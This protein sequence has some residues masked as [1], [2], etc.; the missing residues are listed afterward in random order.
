MRK[1]MFRYNKRLSYLR[2]VNELG[3]MREKPGL[4]N[5][6]KD[7]VIPSSST[8]YNPDV[9]PSDFNQCINKLSFEKTIFL[10]KSWYCVE[11][12]S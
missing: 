11:C 4:K 7:N 3:C 2:L 10:K 5:L 6:S 1:I 12:D 9:I 8:I